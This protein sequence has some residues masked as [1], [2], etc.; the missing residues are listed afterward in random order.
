MGKSLCT[1]ESAGERKCVNEAVF[2]G[3]VARV[4]AKGKPLEKSARDCSK[5][6]VFIKNG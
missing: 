1:C 2:A 5:G 4:V 6:L 3:F